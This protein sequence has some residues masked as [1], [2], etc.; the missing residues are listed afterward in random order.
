[1]APLASIFALPTDQERRR[2]HALESLF[3][4]R[5]AALEE[6]NAAELA[7]H[8]H[9]H[10]LVLQA[11]HNLELDSDANAEFLLHCIEILHAIAPTFILPPPLSS[12]FSSPILPLENILR[13]SPNRSLIVSSLMALNALL[14]NP[15]NTVHLSSTSPALTASIRYLPLFVDK[16]LLDSCLNFLYTHLSHPP[17]AKA[18]LLHHDMPGTIK[19]LV[20]LLL[21]EQIEE[22][23]SLDI[24]DP[25]HTVSAFSVGTKNLE[26]TPEELELL[27]SKPEPD[28]CF[29]WFVSPLSLNFLGMILIILFTRR[30]RT[31]F[32][33]SPGGELTQ[34]EFWTLYKD[35]F[36]P[37]QH[38]SALLGASEVIKHVNS[39]YPQAQAMVLPGPPQRFIVRGVDRR[40]QDLVYE[41]FKCHWNGSQCA[42]AAFTSPA[43]LHDHVVKDHLE[44][45]GENDAISCSWSTCQTPA[46][47]LSHLR[48]HILT[49]FP[50]SQAPEK[51][52][53]QT[54]TITLPSG[55]YPYPTDKPTARPPPPPR[56]AT[57]TYK[58]PTVDPPSSS[59]T[60]LLIIRVL[61]LASFAS[62]D[63][64]PRA[65]ADHFGFPGVVEDPEEQEGI[66]AEEGL[67]TK[68][69]E[70]EGERR[71]RKA[72][73]SVRR[74]LE[75]VRMRDETLMGWIT[76]M[77]DAGVSGADSA[78]LLRDI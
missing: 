71:G 53:A 27:G 30:M 44:G 74:L 18:F 31:V 47:P 34:V 9:T 23:V 10:P 14:S 52:P 32:V 29:D 11:L 40:K 36:V 38:R 55:Q 15:A 67:G 41:R 68:E 33:P 59:L 57:L 12:P 13:E 64:A 1:M 70:Q 50:P 28:R 61:F 58:R 7:A 19:F 46:L 21:S 26:L 48:T 17:M 76:E 35:T 72:F 6:S 4:L 39:V 63:A 62:A 16:P 24:G 69:S 54:D 43:E 22:T 56:K 2:R 42:V 37:F 49:H 3:V 45:V 78:T 60:A 65:D 75:G 25:V 66:G 77:V 51:N 73:L 8:P 20:S 5:N